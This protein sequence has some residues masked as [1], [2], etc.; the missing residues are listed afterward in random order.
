VLEGAGLTLKLK[1]ARFKL[2]T[3]AVQLDHPTQ[4]AE[5]IFTAAEPLLK[6]EANGTPYRLIGVGLSHLSAAAGDQTDLFEPTG[7]KR[8][9]V[10]RAMDAVRAR[11]GR[12]AI[13]TG[14]GI[15]K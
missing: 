9:R 11:L 8:A 5:A 13:G 15:N 7:N 4:L 3:R 12:G 1:T 14:R 2:L 10:E 6:K